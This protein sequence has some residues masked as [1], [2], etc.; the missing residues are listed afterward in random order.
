MSHSLVAEYRRALNY[1][2]VQRFIGLS[3]PKIEEA[4]TGFRQADVFVNPDSTEAVVTADPDDDV[5]IAC[6]VAG[7][8][9]YI[10]SGDRH[11]LDMGEHAGI[12]IVRPT[13]F[14]VVLETDL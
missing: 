4:L 6:A 8:A 14:L 7:S 2:R 9:D 13:T 11:L 1:P 5:V 12:R 3:S 10:V